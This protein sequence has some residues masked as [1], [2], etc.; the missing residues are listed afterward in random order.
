[1]TELATRYHDV[2]AVRSKP[3]YRHHPNPPESLRAL[4]IANA[5]PVIQ[6]LS[7]IGGAASAKLP[8]SVSVAQRVT[9][10]VDGYKRRQMARAFEPVAASAVAERATESWAQN[11]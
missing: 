9:I 6:R 11:S 1:M 8:Y 2:K 5:S 3:K 7:E 4:L 10:A